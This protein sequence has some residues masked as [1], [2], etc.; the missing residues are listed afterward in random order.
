MTSAS[1]WA[2][3]APGWTSSTTS[4]PCVEARRR[5]LASGPLAYPRCCCAAGVLAGRAAGVSVGCVAGVSV[6]CV[7]GVPLAVHRDRGSS[8]VTVTH[9]LTQSFTRTELERSGPRG[10]SQ[11]WFLDNVARNSP[12]AASNLEYASLELQR[13]E[14][15]LKT[16]RGKLCATFIRRDPVAPSGPPAPFTLVMRGVCSLARPAFPAIRSG[17]IWI[18]CAHVDR[19]CTS[20]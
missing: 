11:A 9:E 3:A 15:H 10:R 8:S 19:L 4:D 1:S 7:A 2:S 6:G 5:R 13:F 17:L 12:A 18:G 14:R 16:D 20:G